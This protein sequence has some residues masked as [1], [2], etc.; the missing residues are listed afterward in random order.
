MLKEVNI[1]DI[2][3]FFPTE[4]EQQWALI[5][6]GNEN[7]CNTMTINWGGIGYLWRKNVFF[8]FV[9]K[10]RH[11]FKYTESN[12]LFTITY[13]DEKYKKE[14]G[15]LG[16]V[17]GRDEDKISKVNFHVLPIDGTVTFKEAHTTYVC[18]I[19]YK[20]VIDPKLLDPE[21]DKSVYKDDYHTM[22]IG[23]IIKVYKHD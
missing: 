7:D 6:A 16:R 3:N 15:Y 21:I 17:S 8:A 12:D 10:T 13:F 22:Y 11:T 18:R 19:V 1:K 14:L 20:D 9:R 23:E 4:L 5:T 2:Q